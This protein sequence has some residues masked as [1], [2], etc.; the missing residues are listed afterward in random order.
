MKETSSMYEFLK[1][2]NKKIQEQINLLVQ[3]KKNME[4]QKPC[5]N[6]LINKKG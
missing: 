5:S 2:H 3:G 6:E 4:S 1:D